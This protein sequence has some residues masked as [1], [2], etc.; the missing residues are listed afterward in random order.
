MTLFSLLSLPITWLKVYQGYAQGGDSNI[1]AF[2]LAC[3]LTAHFIIGG[4]ERWQEISDSKRDLL[5]F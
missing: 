1:R 3:V 4:Y 5:K 2:Y